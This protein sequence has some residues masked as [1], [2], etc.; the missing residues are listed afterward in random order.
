VD[1]QASGRAYTA[2]LGRVSLII[3]QTGVWLAACHPFIVVCV[4][5]VLLHNPI[6]MPV[7]HHSVFTGQ[8]PCLLPTNSVKSLKA[9]TL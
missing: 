6:T 9:N 1:N 4:V 7:L 5:R 3:G 2:V 8:M